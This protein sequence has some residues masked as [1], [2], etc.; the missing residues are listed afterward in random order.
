M[1]PQYQPKDFEQPLYEYWEKQGFF[2]PHGDTTKK[3]F[4]I[5]LPPP[6]ITGS[7]HMGHAFQQ[8][9]M[10]IMIRYHRMQGDNTLWQVGTDH[11]GIATQIVVERKLALEIGQTRQALGR[12]KFVDQIWQWKKESGTKITH[13]MKRLGNSV[14]WERERFTMDQGFSCAVRDIFIRLY[15][16]GLIYR[17]KRLVNWDPMLGTAISDIEVENKESRGFLWHI[18][19]PLTDQVQ[20]KEGKNYLVVATTRPETL[21][22]D[23]AIAINPKD[24]RYQTLVGKFVSLPIIKRRIPIIA[25]ENIEMSKGTG[26][27]KITPAHDFKDYEIGQRH[28]LPMINILNFDGTMRTSCEVFDCKGNPSNIYSSKLPIT[29]H[30]LER[31]DARKAILSSLIALNLLESKYPHDLVIPY[32]DRSGVIIEPMLTD[33]WYIR[34]QP[35]VIKALEAVQYGELKFIPKKYEK[36]YLSWM[37]NIQ[38]WCISRQLWWGHRIPAWYDKDGK[39]YVGKDEHEV[40]YANKLNTNMILHQD[41]DVLDT[42]FSSGLWTFSALGWPENTELLRIFHPTSVLVSGFDII[43]FWIARMIMLT[44]HFIKDETGRSQVP[45]NKVYITGLILDEEGQKMSKSKG[46]V[47]DP[48]DI[49][50]GISLEALI[51][52]RTENMIKPKFLNTIRKRTEIKFPHGIKAYGTDALRFTLAALSYPARNIHWD[53]KRLEGY[54]KFCNKLWNASRFVVINTQQKDCGYNTDHKVLSLADRWIRSKL[55]N[56]IKDYIEALNN[57][58]FDIASNI[59]YEFIWHQ[60][61]DWYLEFTKPVINRDSEEAQRGTRY[62]MIEILETILR[63]SHPIIPFITEHIWQRI[64][65]LKGINDPTIML[66]PI[67]KYDISLADEVAENHIDWIKKL[68]IA[69]RNISY[70]MNLTMPIKNILLKNLPNFRLNVLSIVNNNNYLICKLARVQKLAVCNTLVETNPN[71]TV[72]KLIEGAEIILPLGIDI[73]KQVKVKQLSNKI[74]KLNIEITRIQKM[75]SNEL[76]MSGA[77]EAI[78]LKNR[79][80]LNRYLDEKAIIMQN[81]KSLLN[82]K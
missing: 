26:C 82:Y 74:S 41:N 20:T 50:D 52:K 32:G 3:S 28:K 68:I 1:K 64:K 10:D 61:C 19:Y 24:D 76:F 12:E 9:L 43:F 57:Y 55:N 30:N 7:L 13:Q 14:D 75:L 22:G 34:T 78:I 33:Q 37:H 35:L 44:M 73:N 36:I 59:I 81:N 40:R 38:D 39:V 65:L 45:F 17:G 8:T 49:I 25:D 53:M 69:I 42:W 46:N 11:A 60:F 67:P 2:K 58:R 72:I 5:M 77:P 66:Q 70:E 80:K 21:I 6:N 62:T 16:E 54:R 56:S 18:R 71:T 29:F 31:D 51:K 23:T 63:L 27:M 15:R 79:Q 47:I 48:L 4:C